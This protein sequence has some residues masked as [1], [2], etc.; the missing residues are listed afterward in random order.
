VK[1]GAITGIIDW[2][3]AGFRPA[4]L[5]AVA[6]GW[7]NDD[8]D[9]FLMSAHQIRHGNYIDEIPTGTDALVRARFRLKLAELDEELFRHYVQG[10][11][12]RALFYACCDEYP[13]NTQVWLGKYNEH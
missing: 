4:W 6:A 3:M 12:L 1:T 7:F 11:E 9:R 2:E 5:S 10:I 13:G 8:F